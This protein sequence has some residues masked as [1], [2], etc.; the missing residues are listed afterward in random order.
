MSGD[1]ASGLHP[2]VCTLE[3]QL[4]GSLELLSRAWA[5]HDHGEFR[6]ALRAVIRASK[7]LGYTQRQ[8]EEQRARLLGQEPPA[9]PWDGED[10]PT[11]MTTKVRG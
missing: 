10:T 1:D 3:Q 6:R 11:V 4:V 5:R 9:S 8:V 2:R 7:R